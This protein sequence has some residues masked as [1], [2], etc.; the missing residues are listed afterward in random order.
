VK[1]V[2][3]IASAGAAIDQI[4]HTT[5]RKVV[6]HHALDQA[7]SETDKINLDIRAIPGVATVDWGVE[8]TLAELRDIQLPDT[9]DRDGQAGRGRTEKAG[10]DHQC[11][12]GI[13]GRRAGAGLRRP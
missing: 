6:G 9:M 2:V 13:H 11:R 10:Q 1:S 4:A 3:A 12:E 8:V 7:L 5:L